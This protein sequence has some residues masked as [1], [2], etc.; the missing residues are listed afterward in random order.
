MPRKLAV[1]K[2][3]RSYRYDENAN[4]ARDVGIKSAEEREPL[5][6]LAL[7]ALR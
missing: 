1:T 7:D 5:A 6:E 3:P 4:D 2:V